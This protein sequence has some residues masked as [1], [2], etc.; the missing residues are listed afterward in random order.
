MAVLEGIEPVKVFSFFERLSA[1]PRGSGNTKAASD[2]IVSFAKERSLHFRQD[3]ANNVVVFAPASPG[4]EAAEPVILQGHIDMVCEKTPDCAKDM[5]AEGLELVVS[6]GKIS[7]SGTTLGADDGAA[8]A[9]MLAVLDSPELPRPA[10][11]AVFTSDEEIGMVGADA[12]DVSDIRSRRMI[13]MDS[14]EEGVF[15]ASCAGGNVT[16]CILPLS[17]CDRPGEPVKIVISGLSGGH[18]G[19]MIKTGRANANMLLGRLLFALSKSVPFSLCSV[20][21]GMKDNA[22]PTQAEAELLCEDEA[23]I[24]SFCENMRAV[25]ASEYR[26]T[27]PGLNVSVLPC[28]PSMPLAAGS[29]AALICMLV[30]LPNGVQ[31]MSTDIEGLVQTSLSLGILETMNDRAEASFCVRS[32]VESQ[33]QM[34]TDRLACLMAGLGGRTE[35]SGDYPGWEFRQES[36]LRELLSQVFEEQYGRKPLIKAIHAGLECGLFSGKLPGLDCISIGA[37]TSD[38]H[39][40]RETLDIAS[41]QRTWRLLTETLKRMK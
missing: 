14:E 10:I 26:N 34:L 30:C 28:E 27:D 11:E 7:A 3:E 21:G 6:G 24:R 9:M 38:I 2:F 12:L 1:I 25:F 18:S 36:P 5:T 20:R 35:V 15:T 41:M 23:A 32:S 33:K 13:N 29:A 4:Y 17:R 22:I 16:K 8:V 40:P 37:D 19:E 39:T 31:V